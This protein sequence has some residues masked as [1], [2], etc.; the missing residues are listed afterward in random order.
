[1]S[2]CPKG[3]NYLIVDSNNSQIRNLKFSAD[4]KNLEIV[5]AATGNV[6]CSISIDSGAYLGVDTNGLNLFFSNPI[7]GTTSSLRIPVS[8]NPTISVQYDS[9]ANKLEIIGLEDM[10]VG[11]EVSKLNIRFNAA[12]N[13]IY[14]QF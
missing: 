12:D 11:F 13:K 8:N 4:R 3:T 9:G 10:G 2:N 6:E 1:M 7:S 14:Y 5:D